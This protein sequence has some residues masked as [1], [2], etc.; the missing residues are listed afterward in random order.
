M[1]PI[2]K[3]VYYDCGLERQL[4]NFIG[5]LYTWFWRE[6]LCLDY[7]ITVYLKRHVKRWYW[8]DIILIGIIMGV[9]AWWLLSPETRK[10]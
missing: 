9:I 7:P 8:I 4:K 10:G 2:I 6:W 5:G 1:R 3:T